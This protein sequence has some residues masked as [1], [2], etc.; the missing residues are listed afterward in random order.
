[1]DMDSTVKRLAPASVALP[2]PCSNGPKAVDD[3]EARM[4]FAGILAPLLSLVAPTGMS[5]DER[6]AWTAAAFAALSDVPHD[7]LRVGV[8]RATTSVDH[9]S[10]IIPAIRKIVDP[11]IAGRRSADAMPAVQQHEEPPKRIESPITAS[12][13]ASWLPSYQAMALRLGFITRAQAEEAGT[14]IARQEAA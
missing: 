4:R 14:L 8:S 9:P 2:T 12:E 7:L 5:Q 13:I 10:K 11:L 6:K 1:M 3:R